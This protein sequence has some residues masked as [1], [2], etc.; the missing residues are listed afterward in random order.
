MQKENK[1]TRSSCLV[2]LDL[3]SVNSNSDTVLT[4]PPHHLQHCTIEAMLYT[5]E[6]GY[7]HIASAR[8]DTSSK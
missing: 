7:P 1:V 6:I 5:P 3:C 8:L 2:V 4:L